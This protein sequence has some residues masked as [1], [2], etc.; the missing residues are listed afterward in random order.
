MLKEQETS[1]TFSIYTLINE[2]SKKGTA[3]KGMKI[4]RRV[5]KKRIYNRWVHRRFIKKILN[6]NYSRRI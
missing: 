3:R 4:L 1:R 6:K 5:D 2:T